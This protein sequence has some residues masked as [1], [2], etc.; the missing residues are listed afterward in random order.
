MIRRV[1]DNKYMLFI[2]EV[3]IDRMTNNPQYLAYPIHSFCAADCGMIV[4][5]P[6]CSNADLLEHQRKYGTI[7]VLDISQNDVISISTLLNMPQLEKVYIA[8][9]SPRFLVFKSYG[10]EL[11]LLFLI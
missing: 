1:G 9:D 5:E 10:D 3:W 7:K 6:N 8:F 4:D 2:P 11:N